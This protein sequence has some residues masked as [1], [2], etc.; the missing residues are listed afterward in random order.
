MRRLINK[1][2]SQW[3]L[4]VVLVLFILEVLMLP[5]VLEITYAGRSEGPDHILT[6]TTNHLQWDDATGIDEDGVAVLNLFDTAY[7]HVDGNGDKVIAPGTEGSSI[8]RLKN[9]SK[10]TVTFTAVLYRIVTNEAIPV[11]VALEGVNFTQTADYQLPDQVLAEQ[12]VVAVTGELD[13]S[14]IQDFDITW[15]WNYAEGEDQ[16]TMDTILGNAEEE[17]I[18]VGLYILVQDE[19]DVIIPTPP[20]T[21]DRSRMPMYLTLMGI[22]L[23]ALLVLLRERHRE[24]KCAQ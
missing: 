3:L 8:I 16:N 5:A 14:T 20:G 1:K 6:Y 19:G 4:P 7:A 10:R 21:G 2:I 22:S 24:R 13:A 9:D 11:E 18:T 17:G 12:V 15:I 23:V